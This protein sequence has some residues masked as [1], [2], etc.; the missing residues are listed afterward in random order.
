MMCIASLCLCLSPYG[1]FCTCSTCM[2]C[3]SHCLPWRLPGV[4]ENPSGSSKEVDFPWFWAWKRGK[5]GLKRAKK[6][7]KRC[8]FLVQVCARLSIV[9]SIPY[10]HW[11]L[12]TFFVFS[13][14]IFLFWTSKQVFHDFS[15]SLYDLL[16]SFASFCTMLNMLCGTTCGILHITISCVLTATLLSVTYLHFLLLLKQAMFLIFCRDSWCIS[17]FSHC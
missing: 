5:K 2:R 14:Y 17:V 11:A 15:E 4:Y 16:H 8:V 1:Y 12:L 6:G 7:L 9:D 10:F 13:R 3:T